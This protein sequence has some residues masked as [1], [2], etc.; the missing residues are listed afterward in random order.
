MSNLLTKMYGPHI[1]SKNIVQ[2]VIKQYSSPYT[3]YQ[4]MGSGLK[5]SDCKIAKPNKKYYVHAPYTINIAGSVNKEKFDSLVA[6]SLNQL[7]TQITCAEA[8]QSGLIV[9]PGSCYDYVLG[10]Q[11]A[12]NTCVKALDICKPKSSYLLIENMAGQGKT[13]GVDL[14]NLYCIVSS[15]AV[16]HP[17]SI[18]VCLDTCHLHAAGY[19]LSN[20]DHIQELWDGM[21][22]LGL[23]QYVKLWHLNDSKDTLYSLKDRHAGL[24]EGNA[25]T[26]ESLSYLLT[27]ISAAKHD[28]VLEKPTPTGLEIV[29]RYY[30][31]ATSN[32]SQ[33]TR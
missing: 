8:L 28:I 26:E 14:E 20:V 10:T 3:C 4:I 17:D 31:S 30:G 33:D 29:S 25:F 32:P 21:K 16:K 22:E 15:V 7:K 1:E 5:V 11:T 23:L 18:G 19:S 27:L 2:T 13:L 6:T 12:I 24:L 9:H